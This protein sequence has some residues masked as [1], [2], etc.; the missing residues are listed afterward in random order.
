MVTHESVLELQYA[1]DAAFVGCNAE[2]L[3]A[4]LDV[5]VECYQEAGLVI[6]TGKTEAM[7]M[8]AQALDPPNFKIRDARLN[9][10]HRFCYLGSLLS[11]SGNI[12]EEVQRRI[13][14]ASSSFARLTPRVFTS[15]DLSIHTKVK[16]YRAVCLSVLLYAS[17]TW[18][19]YRR[20]LKKLEK[21][22]TECL[23][24]ILGL[25]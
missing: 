8:D 2:G 9:N 7:A 15:R 4:N 5:V 25:K 18:V 16:V 20:H 6:N 13:G 23:Q 11:S 12:D 1:D 17:E 24:R 14:M 3:Q 10:V 22:H 21:F 19:P